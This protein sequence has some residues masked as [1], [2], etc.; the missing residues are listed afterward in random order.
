MN[1]VSIDKKL[2]L[3]G[4]VCPWPVILTLK[5][6]RKMKPNEVIE[7]LTDHVPSVTNVPEAA[8]KEGHEVLEASRVDKGVYKIVI[9]VNK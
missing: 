4:E 5:E 6:V 2:N 9:K 7:I 8:K 3:V 1:Q